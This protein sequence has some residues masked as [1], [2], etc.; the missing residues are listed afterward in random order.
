MFQQNPFFTD[1]NYIAPLKKHEISLDQSPYSEAFPQIPTPLMDDFMIENKTNEKKDDSTKSNLK[2]RNRIAAKKLR[3][4]K[5][6]HFNE[7]EAEN[8]ELRIQALRLKKRRDSILVENQV[9]DR[10]LQFFQ[11]IIS[12]I[13]DKP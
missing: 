4:K 10:E 11:R 12:T 9:L 7:I 13:M 2:E 5:D 3:D 6:K 1:V 8:D